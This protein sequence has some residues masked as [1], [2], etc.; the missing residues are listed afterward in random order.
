MFTPSKVNTPKEIQQPMPPTNEDNPAPPK[1]PK[2]VMIDWKR[3]KFKVS[4]KVCQTVARGKLAITTAATA[5]LSMLSANA[6][7]SNVNASMRLI[8][9][10]HLSDISHN[11]V[12]PRV[13]EIL[14]GCNIGK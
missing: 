13:Y 8:L 6:L 2:V 10:L 9:Y 3:P 1:H 4:L 7:P 11:S 12:V 5:K 14:G